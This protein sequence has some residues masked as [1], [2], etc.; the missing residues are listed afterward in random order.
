MS[1]GN[2]PRDTIARAEKTS[3]KTSSM[4]VCTH[5]FE[6]LHHVA[7]TEPSS[8]ARERV[9]SPFVYSIKKSQS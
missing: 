7:N 2:S 4:R 3:E 9:G 8:R 1:N 5:L 6:T